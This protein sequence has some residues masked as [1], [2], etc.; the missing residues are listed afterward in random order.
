M[1]AEIAPASAP[2]HV[3]IRYDCRDN[4]ARLRTLIERHPGEEA[5]YLHFE[6]PGGRTSMILDD[7]FRVSPVEEF[8]SETE[9]LLGKGTIW[10]GGFPPNARE[11]L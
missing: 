11:A 6:S 5:V 8:F 3:R 10:T 4:L 7:R 1:S 2:V 9:N